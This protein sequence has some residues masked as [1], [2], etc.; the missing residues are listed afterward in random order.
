[1]ENT[2]HAFKSKQ[3]SVEENFLNATKNVVIRFSISKL[4]LSRSNPT[5]RN[6]SLDE[7]TDN[8]S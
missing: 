1:M 3:I 8:Y 4:F 7:A 2:K 5:P 6:K